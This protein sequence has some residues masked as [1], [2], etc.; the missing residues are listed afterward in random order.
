[1]N[2]IS[3]EK[4]MTSVLN[5]LGDMVVSMARS[6][7]PNNHIRAAI[8][9]TQA[10]KMGDAGTVKVQLTVYVDGN[11]AP[12]AHAREVGSGMH[13]STGEKK[14]VDIFPVNASALSFRWPKFFEN[15]PDGANKGKIIAASSKTQTVALNWV[16]HP[17]VEAT[18]YM[19][20]AA[21]TMLAQAP[22]IVADALQKDVAD[23]VVS[24]FASEG[25]TES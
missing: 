5:R 20:P 24:V 8:K 9:R 10:Q 14:F 12:D 2:S 15:P 1:M 3:L 21:D 17:G 6:K 7:A 16:E 18:P 22:A 13:A 19:K 25:F 11:D 4:T 23:F